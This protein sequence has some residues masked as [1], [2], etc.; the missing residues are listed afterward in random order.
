MT[1]FKTL[2]GIAVCG[3]AMIFTTGCFTIKANVTPAVVQQG[4]DTVVSA[5]VSKYP[6]AIPYL[7][8]AAPI[9]CM[10]AN[11]TNFDPAV[12]VAA[13]ESAPALQ[14]LK[15]G[16]TPLIINGVLMLYIGLYDSYV[17]S[18]VTN[19]PAVQSYL[20]ATCNGLNQG[21]SGISIPQSG[22]L[23]LHRA[24]VKPINWPLVQ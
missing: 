22:T 6:T 24:A 21:L 5:A 12:V 8:A 7:Q 10:A 17:A 18:S 13:L 23:L 3:L 19:N 11:G 20:I 16:D 2:I 15:T 14:S 9:I 1:K 4:V